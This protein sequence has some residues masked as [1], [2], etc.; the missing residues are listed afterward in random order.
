MV[1]FFFEPSRYEPIAFAAHGADVLRML[2][3]GFDLFAQAQNTK[4]HTAVQR[5]PIVLPAQIQYVLAREYAVRMVA[6]GFEQNEFKRRHRDFVALLVGEPMR[7]AIEHAAPNAY[8]FGA[9][10]GAES[11]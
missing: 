11:G 3:I 2:G 4:I 8:P 6:K 10:F 5:I 9:H 7:G 1:S